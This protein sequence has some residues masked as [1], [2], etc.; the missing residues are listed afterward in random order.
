MMK[1][2]VPCI[3]MTEIDK[4]SEPKEDPD[5]ASTNDNASR[6]NITKANSPEMDPEKNNSVEEGPP[7]EADINC[8]DNLL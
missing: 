8:K 4:N 5:A 7:T 2:N 3:N 6:Y 1:R